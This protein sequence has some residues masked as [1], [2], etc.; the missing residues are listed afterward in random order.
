MLLLADDRPQCQWS[1]SNGRRYWIWMCFQRIR[2]LQSKLEK[3]LQ[4][5]PYNDVTGLYGPG[6]IVERLICFT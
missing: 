2:R 1:C 6:D 3:N 4:S 5:S